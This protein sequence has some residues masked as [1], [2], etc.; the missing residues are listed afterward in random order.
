MPRVGWMLPAVAE[1]P[2]QVI[3]LR[4]PGDACVARDLR[5]LCRGRKEL[6]RLILDDGLANQVR[7]RLVDLADDGGRFPAPSRQVPGHHHLLGLSRALEGHALG[8][9]HLGLVQ[10]DPVV[11]GPPRLQGG[12]GGLGWIHDM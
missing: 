8:P 11:E 10:Q 6:L 9:E 5:S 3:P 4:L 1:Y 2:V 7:V 12:Q